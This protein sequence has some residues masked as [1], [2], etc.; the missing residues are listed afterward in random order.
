[1]QKQKISEIVVLFGD[2]KNIKKWNLE[3]KNEI[4]VGN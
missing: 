3:K 4:L 1:M 2:E